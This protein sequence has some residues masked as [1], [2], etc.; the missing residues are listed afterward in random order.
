MTGSS[1]AVPSNP[2]V[3]FVCLL[4]LDWKRLGGGITISD[5]CC[6]RNHSGIPGI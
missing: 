2:E 1:G 6:E 4:H 5:V 3:S